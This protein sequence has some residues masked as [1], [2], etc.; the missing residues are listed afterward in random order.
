MPNPAFYRLRRREPVEGPM[1]TP[2]EY[3]GQKLAVQPGEP[4][5]SVRMPQ[6]EVACRPSKNIILTWFLSPFDTWSAQDF[7]MGHE[8]VPFPRNTPRGR[9]STMDARQNIAVP[10]RISYG[11]AVGE[12]DGV[13][14]NGLD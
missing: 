10:P 4:Y 9:L 1:M 5:V 12:M 11:A 7:T 2:A 14:P 3:T 13:S 8:S 6:S